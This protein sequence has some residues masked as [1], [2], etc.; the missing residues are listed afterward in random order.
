MAV[1]H[2]LSD[3]EGRNNARHHDRDEGVGHPTAG[4]DLPPKAEGILHSSRHA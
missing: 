4:A 2:D 3:V 1:A